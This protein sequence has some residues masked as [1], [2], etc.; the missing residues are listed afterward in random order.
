MQV[1]HEVSAGA[2]H[3]HLHELAHELGDAADHA[4]ELAG[5]DLQS[6]HAAIQTFPLAGDIADHA[7]CVDHL[8][9]A[10]G[11]VD[12]TTGLASFGLQAFEALAGQLLVEIAQAQQQQRADQGNDTENGVKQGD[13]H[14][15]DRQPRRVE[16]REDA[17][18]RQE[19]AQRVH[20]AQAEAVVRCPRSAGI[21]QQPRQ[22]LRPELAIQ[23]HPG[24][25]QQPRT[26]QVEHHHDQQ[27]DKRADREHHQRLIATAGDDP[28]EHLQHV[29]RRHQQ[30][31][32]DEEAEQPRVE[33]KRPEAGDELA[34]GM[35]SG[36]GRET[37]CSPGSEQAMCR[38]I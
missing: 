4:R 30:Q 26:Q 33:E 31:Q 35:G 10:H 27:A 16:Q 28:V 38:S 36:T 19:S 9:I 21:R 37:E 15:V 5:G 34:H 23:R 14:Q 20:V 22:H 32:V 24:A 17:G 11:L 29:Q 3:G 2:E 7:E 13:D 18:A 8:G 6:E 1:Y 25:G 12:E